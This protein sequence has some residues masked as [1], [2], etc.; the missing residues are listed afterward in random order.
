MSGGGGGRERERERERVVSAAVT[1][2]E[3]GTDSVDRHRPLTSVMFIRPT[4]TYKLLQVTHRARGAVD[5]GLGVLSDVG[6]VP[7]NAE[8]V[9]V[10]AG[11]DVVRLAEALAGGKR[12]LGS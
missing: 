7:P 2:A 9:S 3:N 12:L 11:G 4:H 6:R 1:Q 8:A 10:D 5:A